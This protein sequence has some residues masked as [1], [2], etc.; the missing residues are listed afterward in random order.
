MH[1]SAKWITT[2]SPLTNKNVILHV[3]EKKQQLTRL[4]YGGYERS[5]NFP[6]WDYKEQTSL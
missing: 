6:Q 1:G 2:A 4:Y 5:R 3:H